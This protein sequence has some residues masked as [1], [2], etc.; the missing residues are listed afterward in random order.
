MAQCARDQFFICWEGYVYERVCTTQDLGLHERPGNVADSTDI[1]VYLPHREGTALENGTD[2]NS[3]VAQRF[4][5]WREGK[6]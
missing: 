3:V 5:E 4:A 1:S 2:E 6:S